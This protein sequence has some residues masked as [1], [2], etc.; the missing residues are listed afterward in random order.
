MYLTHVKSHR[1]FS[2]LGILLLFVFVLQL[3]SGVMICFSLNCDPM[4]IPISRN[5]EDMEDLFTDDFFWLHERGVDY[6]FILIYMHLIRKIFIGSYTT[7][8]ESAW[9]TGNLLLL[10]LHLVTFFGLSLCC[11]HLSEVTLTIAAN[12]AHTAALKY[13]KIYWWFFPNQELNVDTILR[14]MYGHYV[15]AFVIFYLAV[16]HSLEMHYDWKD[17]NYDESIKH[18]F[19]W[20]DDAIK[21][22]IA[23][24]AYFFLFLFYLSTWYYSNS[25]PLNLELFMWGDV[26]AVTDIR[27]YG[28]TP[29]WYFRP[30]MSW[31]IVCPHHY[32]GIG[33]LLYTL[34][35]IY[36]QP[37]VKKLP[38]HSR[39][40][41]DTST[42]L[43]LQIANV[44]LL[45]SVMYVASYLPYGKFYNRI[46][47][48]IA[49]LFS[50]SFIIMF[51][52]VNL[53]SV[54]GMAQN[55]LKSK[56]L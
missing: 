10:V 30:Y 36:Y 6:I 19:S 54:L 52:S 43:V 11:T 32:L 34:L 16:N 4:N 49:T 2:V 55:H 21:N 28:V 7:Y 35:S 25:E 17:E 1:A 24:T 39:L 12:I 38:K 14:L 53:F 13:G 50:F 46:G 5:E 31:L 44:F 15:S 23:V 3:L 51:F 42:A 37:S 9:K 29:H 47:G 56:V 48:N 40:F 22:E 20:L 41:T 26:G 45:F 33:G 18:D 27:F 8:Q